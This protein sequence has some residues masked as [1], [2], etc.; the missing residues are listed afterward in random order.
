MH[1]P[2]LVNLYLLRAHYHYPI[3]NCGPSANP[4]HLISRS[5]DA[6]P[7]SDDLGG[8]HMVVDLL[9]SPQLIKLSLDE[10]FN[11]RRSCCLWKEPNKGLETEEE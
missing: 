10:E 4:S 9:D 2:L 8:V 5:G 3:N 7:S 11:L 6:I 1:L